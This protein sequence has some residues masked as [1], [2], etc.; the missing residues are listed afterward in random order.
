MKPSVIVLIALGWVGT[1]SAELHWRK[2]LIQQ[3]A[4]PA[5]EEA[6]AEYAFTNA[7]PDTVTIQSVHS[8]CGCTTAALDKKV[9]QP[10]ESGR[11]TVTL[12]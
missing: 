9:Y 6:V 12:T 11:I 4:A 7:G 8:S 10:G 3:T 5:D 2:A 1:S